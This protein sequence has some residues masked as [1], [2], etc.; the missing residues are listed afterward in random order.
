MRPQDWYVIALV[1]ASAVMALV[2][3]FGGRAL[4]QASVPADTPD[5]QAARHAIRSAAI[6]SVVGGTTMVIGAIGAKLAST[7]T[8]INSFGAHSSTMS[9][10][11]TMCVSI[12]GLGAFGGAMLTLT[13][14]PRFALFSGALPSVPLPEPRVEV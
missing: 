10:I 14:I 6:M 3:R 5:R 9:W 12:C 7:A 4:A 11:I 1:A 8:T 2:C 13:T